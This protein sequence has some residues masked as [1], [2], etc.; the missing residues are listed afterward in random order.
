MIF[1][2][3]KRSKADDFFDIF[4]LVM[5]TVALKTYARELAAFRTRLPI[6]FLVPVNST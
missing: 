4:E 5:K 2:E 3:N 6:F 1:R